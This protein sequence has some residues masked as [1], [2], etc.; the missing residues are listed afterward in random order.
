MTI[1][2]ISEFYVHDAAGSISIE[3]RRIVT[4][5]RR[6]CESHFFQEVPPTPLSSGNCHSFLCSRLKKIIREKKKE[7]VTF[8]QTKTL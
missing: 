5:D 8:L 7:R 4:S 1:I 3:C 6:N 2:L